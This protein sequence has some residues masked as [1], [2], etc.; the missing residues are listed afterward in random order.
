MKF[1]FL[2]IFFHDSFFL[3]DL[4]LYKRSLN[5]VAVKDAYK[6]VCPRLL[7]EYNNINGTPFGSYVQN[8]CVD[9]IK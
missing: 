5:T 7:C 2:C 8:F 9:T 6:L 1:F 3:V 4:S